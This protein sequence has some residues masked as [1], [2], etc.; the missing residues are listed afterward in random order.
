MNV[1]LV[2]GVSE[3]LGTREPSH[4]QPLPA[5]IVWV[6]SFCY[7]LNV[8]LCHK[9]SYLSFFLP[10]STLKNELGHGRLSCPLLCESPEN[11]LGLLPVCWVRNWRKFF[12]THK[13]CV[14]LIFGRRCFLYHGCSLFWSALWRYWRLDGSQWERGSAEKRVNKRINV[15]KRKLFRL[16]SMVCLWS[17]ASPL[18][19]VDT[20]SEL[21]CPTKHSQLC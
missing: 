8:F 19:K 15:S 17:S 3:E 16:I 21:I 11:S 13:A 7:I 12:V 5:W 6:T 14:K 20:I 9:R 4:T 18:V 10:Q 2:Y 1:F